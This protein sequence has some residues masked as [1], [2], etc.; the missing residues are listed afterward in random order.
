[1]ATEN[2]MHARLLLIDDDVSIQ[3]AFRRVVE[4]A[5][6]DAVTARSSAEAEAALRRGV[7]DVCLLDLH[8]GTESGLEL[9]PVL[10]EAAPWMKVIVVTASNNVTTAIT[11]IRA[12]AVDYLVKPCQPEEL[13][14]AVSQQLQ[15]RRLEQRVDAFQR[16]ASDNNGFDHTSNSP[17]VHSTLELARR[18]AEKD[19]TVLI[20]GENGTGKTVLARQIH[21][22]SARR[23]AIF[24]TVSCPSLSAELLASELFGHV[25]GS[26]TGATD[27]RQGRVQIAEGGTLFLDEIGDLPAALQPKL[28]RFL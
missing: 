28:L 27:N 20:L 13:L 23:D 15:A 7:F 17:A 22:W 8:L 5:G 16:D 25:R 14:H 26:F 19:A 4:D 21:H 24:A 10:S 11:A 18:V 3:R 1:M 2:P 9:L 6:H 12:G